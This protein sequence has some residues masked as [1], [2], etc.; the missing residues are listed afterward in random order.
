MTFKL[1]AQAF[2]SSQPVI[3]KDR[4]EAELAEHLPASRIVSW[5]DHLILI[6]HDDLPATSVEGKGPSLPA[7]TAIILRDLDGLHPSVPF[8]LQQTWD[9]KATEAAVAKSTRAVLVA[10]MLAYRA[11]RHDRMRVFHGVMRSLTATATPNAIYSLSADRIIEPSRLLR[12]L[13]ADGDTFQLPLFVNVRLVRV[14]N[15]HPEQ[16]LLDTRGLAELLLPDLQIRCT[17][18]PPEKLAPFLFNLASYILANGDIIQDGHT[19]EGLAPT[20]RWKCRHEEAL[21]KPPREV[22]DVNP[23]P[24]YSAGNRLNA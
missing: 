1:A 13:P 19:V 9:W 7:T 2:Y 18:L 6:A 24:P 16:I 14:A 3:H 12:P 21:F 4:L 10:E 17:N 8:A 11:N 22:L 23:G 5:T 15:T 20:Q